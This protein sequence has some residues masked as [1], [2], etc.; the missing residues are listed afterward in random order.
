MK[1]YLEFLW[2]V[3]CPIQLLIKCSSQLI[4]YPLVATYRVQFLILVDS[5]PVL[6]DR[7]EFFGVQL[8]RGLPFISK[9]GFFWTRYRIIQLRHRDSWTLLLSQSS[10]VFHSVIHRRK[11]F[12][13]ESHLRAENLS[14]FVRAKIDRVHNHHLISRRRQILRNFMLINILFIKF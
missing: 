5:L 7:T 2:I 1:L 6:Q 11:K 13:I 3:Y 14:S 9:W 8:G 4:I 10:M 12:R